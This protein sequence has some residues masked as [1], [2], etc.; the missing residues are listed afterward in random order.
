[1][2]V[3]HG[4]KIG[5]VTWGRLDQITEKAARM[6]VRLPD[7][8]WF[9]TFRDGAQEN[10]HDLK[11]DPF[12]V[13]KRRLDVLIREQHLDLIVLDEF[14]HWFSHYTLFSHK[15]VVLM[16]ELREWAYS[17]RIG[18]IATNLLNKVRLSQPD[19]H[20][21]DRFHGTQA[22]RNVGDS[23]MVLEPAYELPRTRGMVPLYARLTCVMPYVQNQ[24]LHLDR[25][26]AGRWEVI[27]APLQ[28]AVISA[29]QLIHAKKLLEALRASN[30]PIP[31]GMLTRMNNVPGKHVLSDIR[32]LLE[33][34]LQW[35]VRTDVGWS[36][37]PAGRAFLLRL[38]ADAQAAAT[39]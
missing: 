10:L 8:V 26:L 29:R 36:L 20:P 21:L 3:A 9:D 5:L 39:L 38:D 25:D 37:T 11:V 24:I 18:L 12:P 22:L 15:P 27:G 6:K 33:D 35:I 2:T 14:Q 17:H 4:I 34:H 23:W 13:L 1:M 16:A 19:A 7:L 32:P 28:A 31:W 30:G